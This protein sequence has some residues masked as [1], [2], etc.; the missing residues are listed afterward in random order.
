MKEVLRARL[1]KIK[2]TLKR[3]DRVLVRIGASSS[4][5]A[6]FYYLAR[7]N[8]SREHQATLAGRLAYAR[9][10]RNPR[11]N[12]SLLRRNVHRLEKGLIMRPR[13]VPFGLSYI[14]ETVAAYELAIRHGGEPLELAWARDVLQEY[15]RITPEHPVVDPLRSVLQTLES[16]C[17]TGQRAPEL[18]PYSR[19]QDQAPQIAYAEFLRLAKYRRSVRWYLPKQVPR[20]VIQNAVEAAALSPT[21]CNRLP[22][23][24]RI[25]DDPALVREVIQ[26]PMGTSGFHHQVPGVA[27]IVGKLRNYPSERDRHLIYVDGA[28][29]AM[30]FVYALE[31]QGI[32]SCCI[33][34]PDIEERERRMARLLKLAP[35]ERP[36]MLISFGYPDSDGLVARS[37]KKSL[38]ALCRFNFE[39]HETAND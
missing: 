29:A 14:G 21:A 28:L 37:T 3:V 26:L 15:M 27:V 5:L 4:F 22:Y 25:F 6:T 10:L 20:E 16:C 35:D 33:N 24:F 30:S 11:L 9:S 32:G 18:I 23:E 19:S 39:V 36:V 2:S 13:R 7:G 38:S 1:A 17:P 31:V 34:W 8:F 12:T